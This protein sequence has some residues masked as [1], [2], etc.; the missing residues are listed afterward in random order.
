LFPVST[1]VP[2]IPSKSG[3]TLREVV[4]L[5]VGAGE[6]A[7]AEPARRARI[8]EVFMLMVVIVYEYIG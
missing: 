8:A 3:D 4:P 5:V 2:T 6:K 7:L 1:L